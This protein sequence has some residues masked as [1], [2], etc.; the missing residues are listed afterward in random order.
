MSIPSFSNLDPEDFSVGPST[1]MRSDS[2]ELVASK[3]DKVS[4][5][6]VEEFLNPKTRKHGKRRPRSISFLHVN[7]LFQHKINFERL[8]ANFE[9]PILIYEALAKCPLL[10][11]IS[12]ERWQSKLEHR[13]ARNQV[14][15]RS[16]YKNNF[17]SEDELDIQQYK[18]DISHLQKA[19]S[20][21]LKL[22]MEK[23][24]KVLK[25]NIKLLTSNRDLLNAMTEALDCFPDLLARINS[26]WSSNYQN[27][28]I[29]QV[30][31]K[32]P[33]L[34]YIVWN[35]LI[36]EDMPLTAGA[37]QSYKALADLYVDRYFKN[38][39]DGE[40]EK[41]LEYLSTLKSIAYCLAVKVGSDDSI[42]LA[43]FYESLDPADQEMITLKDL[44]KM[45]RAFC[46]AINFDLSIDF[47]R[48]RR[49]FLKSQAN[50]RIHTYIQN[51][52]DKASEPASVA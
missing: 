47:K 24:A 28:S 51:T 31:E 37:I 49:I 1:L 42:F 33:N 27:I 50:L 16:L 38:L 35:R 41:A 17:K 13:R 43:Q 20:A 2:L 52:T 40:K 14:E 4:Q 19:Q 11:E 39:S 6:D 29:K 7:I 15:L 12:K 23:Q 26:V 45:E 48:M 34:V 8:K 9:Q 44:N 25:E 46:A 32:D 22:L 30:L 3:E 5:L 21:S 10:A 18:E 36:K